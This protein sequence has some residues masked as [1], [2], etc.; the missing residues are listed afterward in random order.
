MLI[1]SVPSLPLRRLAP[2]V[3]L[4]AL[5]TACSVY[6]GEPVESR[7]G[8]GGAGSA[9]SGGVGGAGGSTPSGAGGVTGV[10]GGGGDGGSAAIPDAGS[11]SD[12]RPNADVTTPDITS[13]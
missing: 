6:E 8:A 1:P 7:A 2:W 4:L 5:T 3:S 13:D 12:A 11:A 10:A 9:A